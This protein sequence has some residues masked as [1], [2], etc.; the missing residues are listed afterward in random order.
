MA[1]A[2]PAKSMPR[3]SVVP[4]V[5][6]PPKVGASSGTAV[7]KPVVTVTAPKARVL[8]INKG[9]GGRPSVTSPQAPKGKQ[10]R[11]DVLPSLSPAMI[12]KT[13]MHLSAPVDSDDD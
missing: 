4:G 1:K 9:G 8:R 13:V 3:A 5:D 7:S 6:V 2:T 12:R 10:A 11:V